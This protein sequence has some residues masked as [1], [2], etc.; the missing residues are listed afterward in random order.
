MPCLLVRVVRRLSS[1]SSLVSR[2][3]MSVRCGEWRLMLCVIVRMNRLRFVV[4]FLRRCG[5]RCVLLLSV[6]ML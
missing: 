1:R 3:L 6:L 4:R 2:C 5:L